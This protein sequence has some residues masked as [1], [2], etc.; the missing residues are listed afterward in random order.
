MVNGGSIDLVVFGMGSNYGT[1]LH[2][3]PLKHRIQP[4]NLPLPFSG[5]DKA[6]MKAVERQLVGV[7]CGQAQ[8]GKGLG[9]VFIDVA[10]KSRPGHPS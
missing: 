2:S 8:C 3:K 5:V 7:L 6:G 1:T 4:F 10:A 9:E